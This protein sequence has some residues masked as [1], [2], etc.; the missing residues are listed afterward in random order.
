MK[1]GAT[2]NPFVEIDDIV[3]LAEDGH[4]DTR[5]M[6]KDNIVVQTT[7]K[8]AYRAGTKNVISKLQTDGKFTRLN[9]RG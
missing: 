2:Q 8:Q 7:I 6:V 3:L 1:G 4:G 9:Q 5:R